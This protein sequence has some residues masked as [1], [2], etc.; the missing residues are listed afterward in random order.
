M[1]MLVVHL[2]SMPSAMPL[3]VLPGPP[4]TSMRSV[5][6][7]PELPWHWIAPWVAHCDMKLFVPS[8]PDHAC[9][10]FMQPSWH[11]PHVSAQS[12]AASTVW[13]SPAYR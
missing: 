2:E 5:T 10:R 3:A 4:S 6:A 13:H 7:Y 9:S 1:P 8:Q 11:L 12:R